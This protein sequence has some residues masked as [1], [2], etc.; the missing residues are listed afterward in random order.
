MLDPVTEP[1]VEE[2]PAEEPAG[3]PRRGGPARRGRLDRR[4]VRRLLDAVAFDLE[5]AWALDPQVAL[6]PEPFGALAY[7]FGTRRLSFLKSRKLLRVVERSPSSR[8]RARP[9]RPP[10]SA[11]PS[12]R[13]HAQALAT[14]AET[15]MIAVEPRRP[16]RA[17]ARRADLPDLGAHVRVQ[18]RVRA[19][20]VE[21]GPAR[22]A[23]ADHRRV[24]GGDRRARADAGLL[25]EHRR[26]R[27]DRAQ[28]LL[29]ARRLRDRAPRRREVLD[30][31]LADRRRAAP[32]GCAASD[33]VDVQISLDGATAE[34]NDAR[35]RAPAPT[36]PRSRAM[37]HLAARASRLQAV[38]SSSRA[39]TPSQLDEF[40]AIADRYGAQ[41][42]LTRLRPSGRGADVWDELHPTAAQQRAL[43]DWL[44][45]HGEEVLTG[46][47]FFHLA[48]Y[49]A[50]AAGPEPVRRGPR[51]LPD[52]PG[53]RRLRLPV[54]DPRRRSWPATSASAAASRACGASR[55]CSASCASRRPAAR[56]RA[57]ASTTP[58]AAAAW[59]R[60]SSP[61]LPLDG[62]DPECVLGHGEAAARRATRD[63]AEAVGRPLAAARRALVPVDGS[64]RASCDESPV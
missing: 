10:A 54:R 17:R 40:K 64:A 4:H 44:L 61:G 45:A 18:P 60:S 43:Y 38:A 11:T 50:A 13:V 19:L 5:R 46:D 20:P 7:H 35:P 28:G 14:L 2:P 6:R 23:R 55:S 39:R 62:P 41:L 12:C 53:R 47:S 24:Q 58:A 27:A 42:R 36:T 52:R 31:R 16:V 29:G 25:R 26:R 33:Y 9:A 56:A 51:R 32:R 34:V 59:R 63:A 3:G 8:A 30:Q 48:A 22:P 57:A 21:L 1:A 15:G 49:G 37:E